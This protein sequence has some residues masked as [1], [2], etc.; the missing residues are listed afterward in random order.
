[1][2]DYVR[3]AGGYNQ[4]ADK[5]RVLV[6]RQDGRVTEASE[7]ALAAGDEI[8]V[9]PR[10]QTKSVEITRGI[11]QILYQIAVAAKVLVGL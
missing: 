7:A 11:S 5:A 4:G 1:V 9:L 2:D 6:L 8:M 3:L 10:I